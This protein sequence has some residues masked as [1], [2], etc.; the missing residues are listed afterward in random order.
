MPPDLDPLSVE[1]WLA[2]CFRRQDL[3]ANLTH[4]LTRIE[5]YY[6][7]EAGQ[8][9]AILD[10]VSEG[11]ANRRQLIS[12]QGSTE[13]LIDWLEADHYLDRNQVNEC[14][15]KYPSLAK[16]WRVRRGL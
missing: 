16:L 5:P 8:A 2:T 3:S 14:V 4:L 1:D 15:W 10:L 11:A 9:E 7:A 6:G 13:R 12:N